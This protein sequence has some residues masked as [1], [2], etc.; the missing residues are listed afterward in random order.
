[1]V[2]F[3]QLLIIH[4]RRTAAKHMPVAI[5]IIDTPDRRPVFVVMLVVIRKKTPVVF[6]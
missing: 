5:H 2:I 4:H 1:M 6:E 3:Y